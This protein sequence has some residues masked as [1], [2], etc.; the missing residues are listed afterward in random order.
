MRMPHALRSPG[1]AAGTAIVLVLV[2]AGL[3]A[4]WLSPY[5]PDF[6]Q[7]GAVLEGPSAG[8][9]F[10]TDDLGRDV[11]SRLLYGI[12]QDVIIIVL[13]VPLSKAI[14]IAVGLL[15][16]THRIVDVL[17]QRVLDVKLAFPTVIMGAALA[18]F[19]G[20]GFSTVLIVIVIGGIPITARLTRTAVLTERER[21]YVTGARVVGASRAAILVTHI[22]PNAVD[23][24]VVNFVMSAAGAVFLEGA[25][26]LLGFGIQPPAP[27]LGGMIEKGLPYLAEQHWAVLAPIAVLTGLV[28]GLNMLGD[29]LNATLRRG[30]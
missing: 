23:A 12:R 10:G 5:A 1:G 27:S 24:L 7:A 2:V 16:T 19:L 28:I 20:P 9:W 21:E 30:Y 11:L 4:P 15:A 25:L 17:I 26:S 18:A 29:A 22:L 14:G 8:H 6:Q 13:A 3:L